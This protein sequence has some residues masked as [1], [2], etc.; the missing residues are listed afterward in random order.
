MNESQKGYSNH[1]TLIKE[2]YLSVL[3]LALRRIFRVADL[4]ILLLAVSQE[5][6]LANLLKGLLALL[7]VVCVALILV[8]LLT[9][10]QQ[11]ML[12]WKY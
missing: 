9:D 7:R 11:Y 5:L 10:L 12:H 2:K 4:V 1:K 6:G 3:C 8:H